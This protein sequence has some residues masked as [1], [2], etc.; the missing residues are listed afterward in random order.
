[1]ALF[2]TD[3]PN[4]SLRF[5]SMISGTLMIIAGIL[6][7]F[8]LFQIVVNIYVIC[9]GILLILCDVKTFRFYRF[10][11]F[12]F[13]V[14]GRSLFILIIGSIIIHKGIL[15]LLI[16]LVLICISFM[17]ITVGYYNGIPQPLMDT[18]K[19]P[20]NYYDAKN[21]GMSTC[22]MDTTNEYN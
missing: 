16:G 12:L 20:N 2:F 19:I 7:I 14:I 13:T 15:N 18:K 21:N 17:Y 22:S 5:L 6:N 1:M 8:N 9:S 11:E 3:L 4:F 10:I